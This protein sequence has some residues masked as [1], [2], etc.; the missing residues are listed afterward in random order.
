MLALSALLD[1]LRLE[2]PSEPDVRAIV[3]YEAAAVAFC[4]RRTGRYFGP[5]V[6][7]TE[8]FWPDGSGPVLL[9]D[10]PADGPVTVTWGG[11]A[12]TAETW[13]L[14]GRV[15]S[16]RGGAWIAPWGV[17]AGELVVDYPAG[18]AV[19]AAADPENGE[20]IAD[21]AAPEDVR[22]AVALLVAHWFEQ[23]IP[24]AV[25]TVAPDV[26]LTVNDLLSP[27]V[28]YGVGA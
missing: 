23:R 15:L 17:V 4:E 20:P 26:S 5:V 7:R 16:L 9:A 8:R 27:H 13:V 28:R 24:V 19:L 2:A 6:Q 18:F 11:V 25:G 10:T 22:Q 3:R 12:Y 14:Q 21:V 1:H